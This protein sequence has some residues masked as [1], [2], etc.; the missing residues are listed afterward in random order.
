MATSLKPF[1][2]KFY[3][4]NSV[5]RVRHIKARDVQEAEAR[6]RH[7][8]PGSFCHYAFIDPVMAHIYNEW[9]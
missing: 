8:V 9:S 2:V 4:R 5:H 1:I 3:D 6:I 7:A